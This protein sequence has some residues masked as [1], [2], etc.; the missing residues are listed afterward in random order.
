[1]D[2][3][4]WV[5]TQ[6]NQKWL[7]LQVQGAFWLVN[8]WP[9][10]VCKYCKCVHTQCSLEGLFITLFFLLSPWHQWDV[11]QRQGCNHCALKRRGERPA[12]SLFY[13]A[14]ELDFPAETVSGC[15]RLSPLGRHHWP[16]WKQGS[17]WAGAPAEWTSDGSIISFACAGISHTIKGLAPAFGSASTSVPLWMRKTASWELS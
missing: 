7:S 15:G 6:I 16:L 3:T 5:Q 11:M 13:A 8:V 10:D 9:V 12:A 4:G 17:S 1:M 14:L 2:K